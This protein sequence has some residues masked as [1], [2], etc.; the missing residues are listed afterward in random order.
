MRRFVVLSAFCLW[1]LLAVPAAAQYRAYQE[2]YRSLTAYDLPTDWPGPFYWDEPAY[3]FHLTAQQLRRHRVRRLT[4]SGQGFA[5]EEKQKD[6]GDFGREMRLIGEMPERGPKDYAEARVGWRS[7]YEYD[8]QGRLLQA[9][10]Q[11]SLLTWRHVPDVENNSRRVQLRYDAAGRLQE[12]RLDV[13]CYRCEDSRLSAD[14]S[15]LTPLHQRDYYDYAPN[16]QL[17]R[18]L[19][20]TYKVREVYDAPGFRPDSSVRQP[21][22]QYNEPRVLYF[23]YWTEERYRYDAVG[24]LIGKTTYLTVGDSLFRGA[25]RLTG[26]WH[27]TYNARGQL[28][29]AVEAEG[30]YPFSQF[31]FLEL[32]PEYMPWDIVIRDVDYRGRRRVAERQQRHECSNSHT[33]YPL[34]TTLLRQGVLRLPAHD[35]TARIRPYR[36]RML[37]S[38]RYDRRGQL[39]TRSQTDGQQ[40]RLSF[41][42]WQYRGRREQLD[43]EESAPAVCRLRRR[44]WRGQVR[45]ELLVSIRHK[46]L[47]QKLPPE[48]ITPATP[49][50]LLP[51]NT[52]LFWRG[53][54]VFRW[55]FSYQGGL[56]RRAELRTAYNRSN[57]RRQPQ[58]TVDNWVARQLLL[59]P[60][61]QLS[62]QVRQVRRRWPDWPVNTYANRLFDRFEYE[63]Y[64]R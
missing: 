8:Q 6:S 57:Y 17:R 21:E 37:D 39:Q 22:K 12:T 23:P 48:P 14:Y 30:S 10:W 25:S 16:G 29:R 13:D 9:E 44:D 27:G 63:F 5:L 15:N 49:D 58:D 40:Q 2:V 47:Y 31:G 33:T 60:A 7:T 11:D 46:P 51:L 24:H 64:P 45:E 42:R 52:L 38:L 62:R 18:R 55:Q 34:D 50:S 56:L 36:H 59:A 32:N 35:S 43:Y 1:W 41:A 26:S 3:P 19:T 61:G 4:I 54:S 53:S 28:V 20:K